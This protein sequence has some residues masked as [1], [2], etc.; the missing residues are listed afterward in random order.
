MKILN[1]HTAALHVS[2]PAGERFMI[3]PGHSEEVPDETDIA[4][5][6]AGGL[7][8]IIEPPAPTDE[9]EPEPQSEPEQ[10]DDTKS[11]GKGKGGKNADNAAGDQ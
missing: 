2:G 11:K 3:A 10:S 9:S 5:F 4:L 8:N 6:S 1:M 7:I